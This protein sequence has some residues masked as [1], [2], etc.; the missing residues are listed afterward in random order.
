MFRNRNRRNGS[1][2]RRR[3]ADTV[4]REIAQVLPDVVLQ[5]QQYLNPTPENQGGDNPPRCTYKHFKSCDPPKY[6]GTEGATALLQWYEGMENTFVNSNCPDNLK[7]RYAT[8]TLTK[9]A[10]TWWNGEKRN[11]G[12]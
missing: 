8:A 7:V 6:D 11:L 5:V 9:G 10:L 2:S 4:A 1:S 12:E 3:M